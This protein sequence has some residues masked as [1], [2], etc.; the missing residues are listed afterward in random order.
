MHNEISQI[1]RR[2]IL[3]APP[4]Q[5]KADDALAKETGN[6]KKTG[7]SGYPVLEH[8]VQH[9][10][11]RKRPSEGTYCAVQDPIGVIVISDMEYPSSL[12]VLSF[13]YRMKRKRQT[14]A[15]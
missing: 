14:K 15:E 7:D 10:D 12:A 4:M 1:S 6:R 5:R 8:H 11:K 3:N 2:Y 9:P 13:L